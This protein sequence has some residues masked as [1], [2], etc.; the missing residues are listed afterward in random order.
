MDDAF[1]C[2][3]LVENRKTF[4]EQAGVGDLLDWFREMMDF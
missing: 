3:S 2:Y 4:V 1:Q